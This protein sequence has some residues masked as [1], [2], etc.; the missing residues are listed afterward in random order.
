MKTLL[1]VL[2]LVI[3][4]AAGWLYLH[5]ANVWELRIEKNGRTTYF[6]GFH[7]EEECYEFYETNKGKLELPH[8]CYPVR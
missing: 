4:V 8:G 1:A 7:S 2:A 6:R 3:A 5:P